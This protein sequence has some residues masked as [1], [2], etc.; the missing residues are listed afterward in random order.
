MRHIVIGDVHGCIN[1]LKVLLHS[2]N[3]STDDKVIFV[4]DLIHKGPY[5][6]EVIDFVMSNNYTLVIGNH[7]EKQLRWE[8]KVS[9]GKKI[10]MLGVDDYVTIGQERV[11]WITKNSFLTYSFDV[12]GRTFMIVHGG[13]EN[14]KIFNSD[15]R[16]TKFIDID[17]KDRLRSVLRTRFV[18]HENGAMVSLGSETSED[19]YWADVY[20]GRYG[21]VIF[22][23]QFFK[24]VKFFNYATGIDTGCVY[25]NKLTAAVIDSN[26]NMTFASIPAARKYKEE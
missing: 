1:E 26:G 17:K 21:H 3:L 4:G 20:D 18:S 10:N 14:R 12:S 19:M 15:V 13:I 6:N 8:R 16:T 7:E 9:Y 24:D 2:M 5:Q 22:G 11:D 25:G 23:H